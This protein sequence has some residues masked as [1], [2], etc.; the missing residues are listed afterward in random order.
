MPP[1]LAGREN[2]TEAFRPLLEQ[3]IILKN[4]VLTGLRGLGKT[5]LLETFKP[6]AIQAGWLWAGTDLS[7]S[8]S[9]SEEKLATRLLTDLAVATSSLTYFARERPKAGFAQEKEH[10]K[11]MLDYSTLKAVYDKAPGLIS[12]KLKAVLETVW[13]TLEATRHRGIIFA[14]DEAQ[15]LADHSEKDQYPLSLLLDLELSLGKVVRR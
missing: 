4:L 1:Y 10:I 12:D 3:D 11:A 15:N 8:T 6:M 5:V 7:E 2:E 9:I 13:N 14:Y